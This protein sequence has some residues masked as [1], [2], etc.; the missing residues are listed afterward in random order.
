MQNMKPMVHC[1]WIHDPKNIM[2]EQSVSIVA[3]HWEKMSQSG[4]IPIHPSIHPSIH[5]LNI[6]R[7]VQLEIEKKSI[8]FF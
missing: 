5:R 3:S 6:R 2:K 4:T 7:H 1:K 8:P